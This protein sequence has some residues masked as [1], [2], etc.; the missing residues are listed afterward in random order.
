MKKFWIPSIVLATAIL[1]GCEPEP[2]PEPLP[3][4]TE[5]VIIGC[6]GLAAAGTATLASYDPRGKVLENNIYQKANS[7]ILGNTINSMLVDDDKIFLVLSGAG[8]IVVVDRDTY[9][10]IRR[11][12]GLGAPRH[13]MK[14][15]ENR[16][17]ISDWQLEGIHIYSYHTKSLY[18]LLTGKGPEQ[19]VQYENMAFITNGGDGNADSN[20]TVI[21]TDVDTILTQL[22]V[23][24][25]PNSLVIDAEKK[26][27]VLCSG[28]QK[29][30]TVNSIPGN[31]VS[32][33]LDK[34]NI[35]KKISKL[36][37]GDSLVLQDNQMRPVKL[38]RNV[39]GDVLYYLDNKTEANCMRFN[40]NSSSLSTSPFISGS[41]YGIDVDPIEDDIYLTDVVDGLENGDVLRYNSNGA[42]ED[43]FKVG[44]MPGCFGF[45]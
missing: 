44:I 1:I 34:F 24:Y 3:P 10:V 14:V 25:N 29:Q 43:F 23:G 36:K 26:L 39:A 17:Y 33:N 30:N 7:Y 5:A 40:I 9:K 18:T 28:I 22:E 41:F 4:A 13:I 45:K 8:E 27:W 42:Q 2:K 16:Y 32:I 21:N 12:E 20:V 19:M 31:L 38:R 6:E 37:I 35:V 11:I 15:G